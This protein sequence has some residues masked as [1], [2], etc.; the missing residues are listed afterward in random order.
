MSRI[1]TLQ[2]HIAELQ[3]ALAERNRT[4]AT[5]NVE[6]NKR[7]DLLTKLQGE[8]AE[9]KELQSKAAA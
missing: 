6:L 8:I 3:A 1:T 9:L 4:I 2:N 7:R 5:Q